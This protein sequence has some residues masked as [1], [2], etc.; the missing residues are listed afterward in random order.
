MS[1][2]AALWLAVAVGGA[3]GSVARFGAGLFGRGVAPGWP[4]GTLFV[5]VLGSLLI[6]VLVG[7]FGLRP[8]PDAVRLGLITGVLGGFTTF[9]AF[10]METIEMLRAGDVVAGAVY[11]AVSL[12]LGLAACA[13]G[14]WAT[15]AVLG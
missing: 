6:G 2:S 15:R 11:V 9:S 10:S 4:W 13:L 7:W 12:V 3:L 1:A 14:L 8:A 5:N